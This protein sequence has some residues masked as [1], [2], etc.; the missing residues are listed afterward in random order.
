MAA[1]LYR[2][3]GKYSEV[4]P[5]VP[6]KTKIVDGAHVVGSRGDG[7]HRADDSSATDG[8]ALA[9]LRECSVVGDPAFL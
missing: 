3:L 9:E 8:K 6:L 5:V 4:V 2:G 1:P 7:R